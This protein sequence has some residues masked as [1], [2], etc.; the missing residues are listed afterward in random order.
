MPV[1]TGALLSRSARAW[2][3][4]AFSPDGRWLA[5]A[6]LDNTARVWEV[7]AGLPLPDGPEGL[8]SEACSRIER[9]FTEQE[10]LGYFGDEPFRPTCPDLP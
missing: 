8:L 6:G 2:R 1:L 3:S 5:T 4:L 7:S 10:W 9:N